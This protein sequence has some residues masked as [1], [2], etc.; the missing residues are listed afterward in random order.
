METPFMGMN[1]IINLPLFS[2]GVKLKG[3]NLLPKE[4]FFSFRVY[5]FETFIVVKRS[6]QKPQK[7]CPFEWMED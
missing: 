7:L 4:H 6:E 5:S 3:N 2:V 1:S